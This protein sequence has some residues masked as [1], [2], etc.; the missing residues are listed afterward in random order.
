MRIATRPG[1]GSAPKVNP[2]TA[3]H[4]VASYTLDDLAEIAAYG[5]E[6]GV[7]IVPEIDLPGIPP[8]CWP[9]GRNWESER[10]RC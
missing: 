7:T 8:L 5:A 4:T 9:P 1:S 6:R 3:R 2:A 10:T